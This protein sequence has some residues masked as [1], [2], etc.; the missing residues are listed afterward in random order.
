MFK[1]LLSSVF[2]ALCFYF[3]FQV[4]AFAATA[5][6]PDPNGSW[7]DLAKPVLDAVLH[8]NGWIA[9]ASFLV[10]ASAF[11]LK[12]LAPKYAFFRSATGALVI[13]FS[14]AYGGAV[15]TALSAAGTTALTGA[16][17]LAALK[18][19]VVA[20]GGYSVLRP[21]LVDVVEP[22]LL[23]R[24]PWMSPFLDLLTYFFDKPAVAVIAKAEK[25]G[26]DAVAAKISLGV[27]SV[28][29]TATEIQ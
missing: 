4:S 22:F 18:I 13:V 5:A 6:V 17:A 26:N 11:T 3:G 27:A 28:T 21:L 25:A 10:L 23:A 29:G 19:A 2:V 24:F 8:G 20:A 7:L 14:G 1:V 15:L 16:L 12:V 9:A